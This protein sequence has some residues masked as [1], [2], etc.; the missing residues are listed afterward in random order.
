[1]QFSHSN[2]CTQPDRVDTT[3]GI[4]AFEHQNYHNY[5][6][7]L[8]RGCFLVQI[9]QNCETRLSRPYSGHGEHFLFWQSYDGKSSKKKRQLDLI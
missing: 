4:G 1:M 8:F 5:L 7:F 6:N 3:A 9:A 2:F